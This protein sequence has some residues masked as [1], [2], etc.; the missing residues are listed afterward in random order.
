[1]SKDP[2]GYYKILELSPGASIA[3]VRR[4]YSRQ[5]AK[6]HLDSPFMKNKLKNAANDEEREKIKKECGEM[7][8][9][10]NSAKSVLFD[11][12]KKK[13]YDSGVG[14]FGAHFS[15]A[16]YSDIFDIFSQFTGGRS[17]QRTNKVNSTKY[18]I[19]I[20]LRESFV[21][22]V[23]K[24]NVRTEK[25]CPTCDGK[26]GKDVET[27]KKCNG[28]GVCTTRRNLGGFVTL[29]EARCDGCEGSGHKIKGKPCG[30]CNGGEYIQD[31][32]MFEVNIKPGVRKGEKIVFEGMGDQRR[33]HIP[34][35]VIFIIDV[36]EDSRF[37]RRGNDLIGKIDI[38]LCTAIGGGVAYFTHIDGRLLEISIS[39]F[40]TFDTVL[41]VRNEGF[42]GN[43]TGS[44]VLKPN[45]IIGSESDR[46]KIMQ[47][48]SAPPRKPYGASVRVSSEFGSMPEAEREQEEASDDGV[49]NARSFFNSFS[50]F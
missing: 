1:M 32:T 20:S 11:E 22:K 43:K 16:G 27:C 47:V 17:H 9:K 41:R 19:T 2:K 31:K 4:A 5:Q 35:D 6:Y 21:G 36:Q 33:N 30:T 44:L 29:A 23:S 7:S 15:G 45:I 46:A 48:L 42:K 8:A 12:K 49:H 10:L 3:D 18:V 24:F 14:E 26:G 40:K 39:P 13:E 37:E 34:G 38:P 25:I 28:S 50:F